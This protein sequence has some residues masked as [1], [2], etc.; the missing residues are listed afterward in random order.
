MGDIG[1]CYIRPGVPSFLEEMSHYFEIVIFTAATQEYADW[2]IGEIDPNGFI[3][4]RLYRQ[5]TLP[6][7]AYY[8]KVSYFLIHHSGSV[9]V[10]ETDVKDDYCG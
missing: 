1:K 10:G 4:S 6:C 8:I 7:G 9:E 5:H 2:A 3:S